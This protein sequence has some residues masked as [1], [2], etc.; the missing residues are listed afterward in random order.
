MAR[1]EITTPDG[2]KYEITAPE[3]A[4]EADA[5]HFAQS[6]FR[7]NPQANY[8]N[9]LQQQQAQQMD[10]MS[11]P[12]KFLAGAGKAFVDVG[13]GVG[14]MF[15]QVPQGSV[16]EARRL[17]KPLMSDGVGATGNVIGNLAIAAPTA[18]IPGA[19]TV[20]GAGAI[21]AGLNALQPVAAGESRL[22]NAGIGAITGAG[23]QYG[24]GKLGS[25]LDNRVAASQAKGAEQQLQNAGKDEITRAA[26]QAGLSV[27]PTHAN[28]TLL[29]RALEGYAG[30]I[31]TQQAISIKNQPVVDSLIK[32][33]LGLAADAKVTPQVLEGIRTKAYNAGYAPIKAQKALVP[34]QQFS[35]E[36]ASLG[37]PEYAS[38]V[39]EVPE[40]ANPEIG[41]LTEALSKP[42]FSGSTAV[43]LIRKLRYNANANF[44]NA[45]NPQALELAHAQANAANALEG[46]VERNL[47]TRGMDDAVVRFQ[48]ARQLIAKTH[49]A[50]SALNQSGSF[51]ANSFT[52]ALDKGKPL[53][54][55]QK[56]VA[57]FADMYPKAAQE[58]TSAM[59][60]V[61]PLDYAA[62][63]TVAAATHN[64]TLL[65]SVMGRPIARAIVTSGPY[66]RAMTTPSYGPGLLFSK[67][68]EAVKK[69]ERMGIAGLLAPSVYATQQ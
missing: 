24:L 63:G 53:T 62:A 9:E 5:L 47:A 69:L 38:M 55:N 1:F 43:N 56:L 4:T 39:A 60:G 67:S 65:A 37:G 32:S 18:F 7:S 23:T 58:V 52:K 25:F 22:Q 51:V 34:D 33:D 20:V 59:P 10:E 54:G 15:G 40:M 45:Q 17:E 2:G 26:Q 21:G 8:A 31:N 48:E 3:G 28:P 46:M 68:P 64:P 30:K 41:K 29:N 16:D 12:Q 50:E 66:Q 27:S 19:N 49:T 57:Q 61:S 35:S 36:I 44:K 6:Q 13:R 42:E 14:Q 11:G